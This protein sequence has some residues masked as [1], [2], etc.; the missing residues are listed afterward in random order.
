MERSDSLIL[1]ILGNLVHFRNSSAMLYQPVITRGWSIRKYDKVERVSLINTI[2][3]HLV[4]GEVFHAQ[5]IHGR[6]NLC[7]HGH[8]TDD[9]TADDV[10]TIAPGFNFYQFD[11]TVKGGLGVVG[12]VHRH[13]D[14]APVF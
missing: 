3:Q 13:L 2:L 12:H 10:N 11:H 4:H 7:F 8:Q 9:F 14:N 6:I 5:I 1:V